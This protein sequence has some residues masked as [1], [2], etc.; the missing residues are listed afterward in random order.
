MT[1]QP[2]PL[3][4]TPM[5]AEVPLVPHTLGGDG[6]HQVI[7][8]HMNPLEPFSIHTEDGYIQYITGPAHVPVL[9][10]SSS[11]PPVY[12]SQVVEDNGMRKIL[13][14]P[15][16]AEFHHPLPP[17]LP[18]LPHYLSPHP[19]M[20]Q[21]PHMYPAEPPLPQTQRL[22]LLP[23]YSEHD[24]M[25]H[26]VPLPVRDER[27]AKM[28]EQPQRKQRA[29]H[30]ASA[31]GMTLACSPPTALRLHNGHNKSYTGPV[32]SPKPLKHKS[33]GRT[34]TT[35]LTGPE[36]H[37]D[38]EEEVR[39][40]QELLSS[41]CKPT[42]GGVTSCSAV[43]SWR[44]PIPL[45]ST[46]D[47][48]HRTP[49]QCTPPQ[50]THPQCT[51]P[52]RTHPQRTSLLT[53][54]LALSQSGT[55]GDFNLVYQGKDTSCTV[56]DLRPAT[57]YYVRVCVA[58]SSVKGAPSEAVG[59][60]TL[61]GAPDTPASP[62]LILRTR[63]CVG[64]QWKAP[65][66]NGSKI[67][68]FVLE[69]SEGKQNA[70][71]EVYRGLAKH[72]K[73]VR[74]SPSTKY[75]FRIAAENQIGTS[76]FSELL[77]CSTADCV[78]APPAPPQL[79]GAGVTWL[80]LRWSAPCGP[81][82]RD[83]LT[84]IVE[85]EED[86]SG[87]GFRP[88]HRGEDLCCV[89]TKLRRHTSYRVRLLAA[90]SEGCSQPSVTVE[91]RTS[92]DKP[93]R[94][95]SPCVQGPVQPHSLCAVWDPP[96]DDGG[97]LITRYV[98]ELC[99]SGTE[100]DIVYSGPLRQFVCEDLEA[101]KW[102]KLR[103][104][105]LSSGGQ[106][107]VS[108][109]LSVQTAPVCPGM[110]QALHTTGGATSSE[111]PLSWDPPL[112]DG[113][114]QVTAY[115]VEMA[116]SEGSERQQVYRGSEGSCLV[117]RLLPDTT[118]CFWVKAAN[119]AG[120]G[121]L[122]DTCQ[123]ST[124]PAPPEQCSPP[125]LLLQ[126]PSS[127][128]ARWEAP[129]GRGAE[130]FVFRLEWGVE[131]GM[132]V[133][134]Y[135]GPSLQCE[136]KDLL[137]ATA[138]YCRVQAANVAGSGTFSHVAMVTTP[139][140]VPAAVQHVEVVE[141]AL[142]DSSPTSLALQWAE[143]CCH[144]AEI[145]GYNIDFGDQLPLAVGRVNSYILEN[146]QPATTYRIR[147][148]AV[149]SVG[150]GPFSATLK[151]QTRPLPPGPLVLECAS[152]GPQSLKLRWA[153]GPGGAAQ[154]RGTQ[155]CLYMQASADRSV[156]IYSGPCHS[157][158]V[159]RLNEATVYQ[160]C[161]QVHSEAGLGPLSPLYRFSTSRSPPAQLRAPR[162]ESVG[163]HRY[164]VRWEALQPIK[165]DSVVYML[166]LLRGRGIE[167]LYRGPETVYTWHGPP[168]G[169]GDWRLRVCAGRRSP[170][171]GELWGPPS[172]STPLPTAEPPREARVSAAQGAQA[173]RR[174]RPSDEQFAILLLL[175]FATLAILLAVLIQYCVIE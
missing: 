149:N 41:V 142:S 131:K 127:V 158:K 60:T 113:G 105:C 81:V 61:C 144:G 168:A 120:W 165:G 17:V 82:C 25:C 84:Y 43:L 94:P 166:Q 22:T 118:Y 87:C 135:S 51:P 92:P 89:V 21:H 96:E 12:G 133:L 79:M 170:D 20:L 152:S 102:Y 4:A 138:Y 156:C 37:R 85:M 124:T 112:C 167:Q 23:V 27:L 58:C 44:P 128:L 24:V 39:R 55:N 99:H 42:V 18:H 111:I 86:G 106:S 47:L 28:Q 163:G 114:A 110:C 32:A 45:P 71:K 157:F 48:P 68:C 54:E 30:L 122:S 70:F 88:R 103:V 97:S 66:D 7:Y 154:S 148:Q 34:R 150:A 38:T 164:V 174:K 50:R 74:L 65:S 141:D 155:Y 123:A 8:L 2:L 93:S 53:Y 132:M 119:E 121:P 76:A 136:L 15:H 169:S 19:A 171:S 116:V 69:C 10:P 1:D 173:R 101:G 83:T 134:V 109:T 5:L 57:H 73:V 117:R 11:F 52:Q 36:Q 49:P 62:R 46:A 147:V 26:S 126:T 80:N 172:L 98:L 3:E 59:F 125:Q 95:S 63:S 161:I 115:A 31:N 35:P 159:Q 143:P 129:A 64:L 56:G 100:W 90:N 6:M 162:V 29:G 72:Y 33:F 175:G 146:L 160:F 140:S 9:S 139:P 16:A 40:V 108:E 145:V 107:Q 130:V 75:T 151:A 104:Y 77:T 91:Y 153:D 13:V 137:P 78:P 67:S 14:L